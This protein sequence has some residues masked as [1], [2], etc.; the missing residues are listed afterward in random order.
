[1]CLQLVL[2]VTPSSSHKRESNCDKLIGQFLKMSCIHVLFCDT[3][4]W[5][6]NK[7]SL[8]V[9]FVQLTEAEL[10]INRVRDLY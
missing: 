6:A 7:V 4:A 2:I 5:A 1:M 8:P 3:F 9:D 10:L